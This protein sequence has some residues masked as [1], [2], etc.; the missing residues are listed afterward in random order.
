M[1]YDLCAEQGI[2]SVPQCHISQKT[3]SRGAGLEEVIGDS[4]LVKTGEADREGG[5]ISELELQRTTCLLVV[6]SQLGQV[7]SLS[8]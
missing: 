8:V 2:P 7:T 3:K 5:K 1:T 4:M 6:T